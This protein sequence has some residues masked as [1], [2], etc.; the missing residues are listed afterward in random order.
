MGC[1]DGARLV[2]ELTGGVYLLPF[3][4]VI[5]GA[6]C[7]AGKELSLSEVFESLQ[8]TSYSLSLDMLDVHADNS[9]LHRFDRFNLK[10]NPC[11]MYLCSVTYVCNVC[12]VCKVRDVFII[13]S[14]TGVTYVTCFIALLTGVTGPFPRACLESS[15]RPPIC[16]V[17]SV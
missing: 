11:G 5:L 9:T 13:A 14:L 17:I 7:F 6:L 15:S 1:D 16:S 8:M 12:G 3:N 2:D 10:Y 4:D